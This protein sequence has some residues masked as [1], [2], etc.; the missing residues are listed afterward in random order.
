MKKILS[1]FSILAILCCMLATSAQAQ[2]NVALTATATHSGGGGIP[3]YGPDICKDNIIPPFPTTTVGTFCWVNG[4]G[5]IE[6]TWAN[7]VTIDSVT[8]H[9]GYATNR[10]FTSLIVQYW[11]G[12]AYVNIGTVTGAQV[13]VVGYQ[14]P[15][16]ITTTKLRFFN[17][18]G[19]NPAMAEIQVWEKNLAGND[20]GVSALASPTLPH[21]GGNQNL[22]VTVRNFGTNIINNLTLN[23]QLNGVTQTPIPINTP[24]D[25]LN[26]TGVN[27]INVPLQNGVNMS[28]TTIVK[29]WT[30]NPNNMADTTNHNDTLYMVMNPALSGNYTIN[31]AQVTGGTNFQ[32]IG[33]FA[34]ALNT[35]GVCGPV[36]ANVVSGSGPYTETVTF[37][38]IVGASTTNTIRLIGN[39]A[40]IQFNATGT[41]N[42]RIVTLDGT[43]HLTIDNLKIKTLGTSYGWGVHIT[44][45]AQNDSIIN[46]E[47]NLSTI[48]S[49]ASANSNGIVISG[50]AT[51]AT[52]A[53]TNVSNIYILNNNVIAG[54]TG[55]GGGYYG[56]IFVGTSSTNR[57]SNIFI[58]NNE[59]TNFYYYGIDVQ[60]AKTGSI[61][62][63]NVHRPNKTAVTT[64]YAMRVYYNDSM[65]VNANRIHDLAATGTTSTSALYGLYVYYTDNS[66][67]SNNAI[68]NMKNYIASQYLLYSYYSDFCKIFHNTISTDAVQ[69]ANTGT[70][71]NYYIYYNA[72][73][74]VKNNLLNATGG[75]TG[76][77]YGMYVTPN[78]STTY[79]VSLQKNNIYLSSSQTGTQTPYYFGAAY[80]SLAAFQAAQPTQEIGSPSVNPNFTG[81]TTGDLTPTN[82]ALIG[83]GANVLTDVPEDIVGL[84]RSTAPTIGAFEIAPQGLNNARMFAILNPQGNVCAGPQAIEVVVGNAGTNNITNMQI[85]WSLNG[86]TQTPFTYS[87]PVYPTLVPVTSPGQFSDTVVIGNASLIN[88]NNTIRVWTSLPNGQADSHPNNDTTQISITPVSFDL[89]T[90]NDTVCYNASFQL[91]LS[92]SGNYPANSLQWESSTNGGTTWSTLVT[93]NNTNYL[94]SNL[95]APADY[96]VKILTGGANCYSTTKAVSIFNIT[97][98]TVTDGERCGPGTVDLAAATGPSG[99]TIK[100]YE[101][102]TSFVEL[103]SGPTFTTPNIST[104]TTY[105]VANSSGGAGNAAVGIITPVATTGNT[106]FVN[107]GVVFNA[108]SGF[109]LASVDVYPIS[110]TST[111]GSVTIALK[112]STGTILQSITAP[113][114]VSSTGALNTIPL[115][116]AITPGTG[117]QLVF[118]AATGMT[119]MLRESTGL[120]FPYTI[121]GLISIT[122]STTGSVS[123]AYYYYMYNLKISSGCES[124]R[125]PVLATIREVPTP[126]L[127]SDLDTCTFSAIAMTLDPGPQPTGSTYV[128]ENNSNGATRNLNVSGQY[129]VTITTPYGCVASD[130][131][132]ILMREK[133]SIDLATNGNSFCVGSSKILDAGNGG[134]NGGSYYW[135]T[136]DQ[137][138]TI[139]VNTG[140]TYIVFVT[141]ADGCSNSDTINVIE[142]GYAPTTNGIHTTALPAN[143]F[144]FV[145]INPQNVIGYEW[146]FGD[147]SPTVTGSNPTHSY[148]TNGY[149]LVTMKTLSSCAE[150]MDSTYVNIVG[151]GINNAKLAD[152]AL[153]LFPNPNYDGRLTIETKEDIVIESIKVTNLLGQQLA[154]FDHFDNNKNQYQIELPKHLANGVYQLL[155]ETN[156][157]INVK[158]VNLLK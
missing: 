60:Y 73:T 59:V 127:G 27:T 11:N 150:K 88:G 35:Y 157:G 158:K 106:A 128:W 28:T 143:E 3:N 140:G 44:G 105:Y 107:Y 103:G 156:K 79:P 6:Y 55:T 81:M 52:T 69:T 64:C 47:I 82:G 109:N 132:N 108:T 138:Q 129:H 42:H 144:G 112:N 155:I 126:N 135:N 96:R 66:V 125:I 5:W 26:G 100:W 70:M 146:D 31:S 45:A 19:S 7:P 121:P 68:Y 133:P 46:S 83:S 97:Q 56:I 110:T 21:C 152:N 131:I 84:P 58:E 92:P 22:A 25:T 74:E 118:T 37:G 2:V 153:S 67:I 33:D 94:V 86:V 75:N 93:N 90:L 63:N 87:T 137:T 91:E 43:K 115:N 65:L 17:M 50:S 117:Y 39:G 154:T 41:T 30:S 15:S 141:S 29:A 18:A 116:F 40:T 85:N 71:Y 80:A 61:S 124:S 113:V 32:S 99:G 51:S 104:T 49:T 20:A 72:N 95:I 77:K 136:G 139:T 119:S 48:T 23:W 53:T 57:S 4:N 148:T 78:N 120:A 114:V 151:V 14:F 102:A 145:A 10:C 76:T 36:V 1:V 12:T 130:T 142:N 38:N 122:S 13:A 98:P 89:T 101:S 9:N 8:F 123:T 24:L 147:G 54:G 149:F 16:I 62:N 111:S 134:Q 34:T